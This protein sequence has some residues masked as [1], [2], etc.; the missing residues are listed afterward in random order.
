M[1]RALFGVHDLANG[2][3]VETGGAGNLGEET[4]GMAQPVG[5]LY[6]PREDPRELFRSRSSLGARKSVPCKPKAE[7]L[8]PHGNESSGLSSGCMFGS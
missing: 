5:F 1:K 6:D 7:L 2:A 3:G 8:R 4:V